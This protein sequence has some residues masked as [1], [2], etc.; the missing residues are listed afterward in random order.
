MILRILLLSIIIFTF[1]ACTSSKQSKNGDSMS[2][3]VKTESG[4]QYQDI[5]TGSGKNPSDGDKVTI[6]LK[7]SDEKGNIIENSYLT[8]KPVV[9]TIGKEEVIK[10][11]EEG[12]KGI[13]VGGKRKL[14]IPPEIGFGVRAFKNI[15]SNSNLIMEVELLEIK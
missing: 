13:K 5:E 12:V 11:L 8:Q 2:V 14:I 9:F 3:M 1:F 4:L 15:P 10:G 6:H 7:I